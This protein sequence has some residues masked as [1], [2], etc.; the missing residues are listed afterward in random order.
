[1][2]SPGYGIL[3]NAAFRRRRHCRPLRPARAFG[4]PA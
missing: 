2:D 1:M 4:G 3:I